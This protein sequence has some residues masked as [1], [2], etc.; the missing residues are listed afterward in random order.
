MVA[1]GTQFGKYLI[2]SPLGAGGMGEVY[3]ARDPHLGRD[4]AIKLLPE[5]LEGEDN[6][7]RRFEREARALAA[8]SHPNVLTLFDFGMQNGIAFAVTELLEGETLRDRINRGALPIEEAQAIGIAVAE[9]LAAAH[10]KGIIHRDLKPENVFLTEAGVVKILDF[11]LARLDTQKLAGAS[12]EDT[13]ALTMKTEPGLLMGTVYYMSPE[14][15]RGLPID[16]RCDVFSFGCLLYEMV[17]GTRAFARDTYA[18]T[19]AAILRDEPPELSPT[20]R[21]FRPKL[22]MLISRCLEKEPDARFHTGQELATALKAV[23]SGTSMARHKQQEQP[24]RPAP[25]APLP[26]AETAAFHSPKDVAAASYSTDVDEVWSRQAEWGPNL[27]VLAVAGLIVLYLFCQ[28]LSAER[29]PWALNLL[30]IGGVVL[31]VLSYPIIITLEPPIRMTP[32][33]AVQDF[34]NALSHPVPHYR[35]MWLLLSTPGRAS[36]TYASYDGFKYYWKSRLDQLRTDRSKHFKPM[37]LTADA[38]AT[39][40][41]LK[42][43]VKGRLAQLWVGRAK[44]FNPFVFKVRDFKAEKSVGRTAM[45]SECMVEVYFWGRLNEEPVDRIRLEIGL[46]KG[47]DQMWYLNKGSLPTRS[48]PLAEQAVS[49][50]A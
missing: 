48:E 16:A 17:T 26:D 8:L 2:V 24:A 50:G 5:R 21:T 18:E 3:R 35:R 45:D 33:Q 28:N 49:R 38:F 13:V 20:A 34:Y 14:Q 7:L 39:I 4:V 30:L 41:G 43:H 31:S 9:G 47:P 36:E 22:K 44:R 23:V 42:N 15:V 40:E 12:G 19:M 25:A 37:I 1:P 6:A 46:A 27:A 29:W 32:G 10:A 11:G